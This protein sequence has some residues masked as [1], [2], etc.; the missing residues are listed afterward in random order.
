MMKKLLVL[1]A[2]AC[3][4]LTACSKDEAPATGGTDLGASLKGDMGMDSIAEAAEK[5]KAK[6]ASESQPTN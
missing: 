1:C 3:Y 5:A 4:A 2:L 6:A